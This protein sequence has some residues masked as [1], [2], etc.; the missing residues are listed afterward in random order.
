MKHPVLANRVR[1]IVWW[2]VWLFLA[3]GQ[4]LLFYFTSGKFLNISI[5]DSLLSLL[6]YSGIALSLWY[7]FSYFNQGKSKPIALAGN[8][9]GSGAITVAMWMVLT[10][11]ILMLVLP[12]DNLYQEFWQATFIYRISI[13]VFI[14]SLIILTYYLFTTLS[15]LSE[16]NAREA[17]L[18]ALVRETELKMLR[19]QI[20]PHFLFNS[21][22]SISSLTITDPEKARE[23]I[24]KLSEF[25]RYALSRKDEQP[26]SLQNELENLR[27]YLDIEKVRFGEKL[28]TEEIIE[29]KCLGL[30]IPVMLLQPL[31]EN[32]VKHGVYESTQSVK[33][34]T[35]AKVVENYIEII[36]S[37]NYD[38]STS[39]KKGT[40]TG[41]QN[42]TRRLEL[43]YGRKASLIT[44]KENG[45]Y[46]A[47]L[48]IPAENL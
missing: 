11:M 17:K 23:M 27:L 8:L 42:V 9:I 31:Y 33:I 30:K 32:A 7:P 12:E 10:K 37:N 28:V 36:I 25:M 47:S 2:L 40:G 26:V 21:L 43:F 46:K 19:S 29:N 39:V 13:G 38:S 1:L 4:T 35:S 44:T 15:N 41:L 24:V 14:Y 6:L 16:K 48:Y 45:I 20:N 3:V 22:N 18:E 5:T 34:S